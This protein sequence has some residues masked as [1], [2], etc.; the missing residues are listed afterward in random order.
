MGTKRTKTSIRFLTFWAINDS[1][2]IGRLKQQLKAMKD[3]GFQ[4]TVF[5]PRYYPNDP[6]YL[7]SGYL[8]VCLLYTSD[9]ADE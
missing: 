4:G 1:L 7:G 9:A 6:P 8:G 5:H 2:E 3:Y